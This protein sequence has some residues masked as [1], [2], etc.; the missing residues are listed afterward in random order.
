MRT[1]TA[2]DTDIKRL[3]T[4]Y[5]FSVEF[6][7]TKENGQRKAYGAGL[8]SSFGELEYAC[9][10]N[11][12]AFLDWDPELASETEYPI[13]TFQPQ[14]FVADSLHSAAVQTRVFCDVAIKRP[15]YAKFENGEI[16]TVDRD[17]LRRR[18]KAVME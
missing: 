17:V 4:L 13:T 10:E 12:A 14:Y 9:N 1:H 6:G 16:V 3:A 8:L 7:L 15:F 18:G 11:K 2:S 5:W